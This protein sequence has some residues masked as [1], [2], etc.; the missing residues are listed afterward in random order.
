MSRVS[1]D[2]ITYN[3]LF[4]VF[5][6]VLV[7]MAIIAAGSAYVVPVMALLLALLAVIQV[8][9]LRSSRQLRQ[10]ELES[11]AALFTLFT[12]ASEGVQHIRSF[13]WQQHFRRELYA[14]LDRS[15]KPTYL[16]YC[17]QRWLTLSLD[18]TSAVTSVILVSVTTSLPS[19]TTSAAVGLAM[20][21]LMGFSETANVFI[22]SWTSVETGLGAVRRIKL[23]V[24]NT[25]QEKDTLSAPPVPDNWPTEG[26]LD[27][28]CLTA[29]YR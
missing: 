10:I 29:I 4:A 9:Y 17:I 25:P 7:E 18:I 1:C 11:S 27:F 13:G 26:K 23:F 8:F 28:N 16:L 20:L 21:G 24:M 15:Q 6:T 2:R 14:K 12:E 19:Q 22:Q 5:F 3:N